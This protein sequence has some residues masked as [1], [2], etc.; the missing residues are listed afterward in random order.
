M[1][2]H[3]GRDICQ[4]AISGSELLRIPKGEVRRISIPR[5]WVN[6]GTKQ[7][8]TLEASTLSLP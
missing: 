2:G 5:T 3:K 8:R 4:V 6:K 7:G 1:H